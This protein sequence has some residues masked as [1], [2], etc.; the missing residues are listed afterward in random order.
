MSD[1]DELEQR[2]SFRDYLSE[3]VADAVTAEAVVL[4]ESTRLDDETRAVECKLHVHS[5]DVP[6]QMLIDALRNCASQIERHVENDD[7]DNPPA[8]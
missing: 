6:P 8:A 1:Y 5:R 4:F 7:R 3:V 2:R